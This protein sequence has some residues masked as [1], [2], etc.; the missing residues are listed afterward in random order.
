MYSA[1]VPVSVQ[2]K[3]TSTVIE[4]GHAQNDNVEVVQE[5]RK[6]LKRGMESSPNRSFQ[7]L[8]QKLKNAK[9]DPQ[10]LQELAEQLSNDD[11]FDN[12]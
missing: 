1:T 9:E 5:G 12:V 11:Q 4:I 7:E 8:M 3:Q 2:P 10:K 6:G